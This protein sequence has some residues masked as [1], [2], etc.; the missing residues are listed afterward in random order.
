[1]REYVKSSGGDKS[2]PKSP[3]L[4]LVGINPKLY[5]HS[6]DPDGDNFEDNVVEIPSI[7]GE[8]THNY[9]QYKPEESKGKWIKIPCS[10]R[11]LT[12]ANTIRHQ[13]GF[14]RPPGINPT[15]CC[16]AALGVN[17]LLAKR[18]VRQLGELSHNFQKTK[19]QGTPLELYIHSFFESRVDSMIDNGRPRNIELMTEVKNQIDMISMDTGLLMT[20]VTLLAIYAALVQQEETPPDFKREWQEN[21]DKSI[22]TLDCKLDMAKVIMRNLKTQNER[23][24]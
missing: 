21:L 22:D 6:N 9:R 15:L 5:I 8:L 11:L 19:K 12:I 4:H 24:V 20:S 17:Q 3:F 7:A 1:M 13:V 2:K 18:A 23:F 16:A 14:S 10:P